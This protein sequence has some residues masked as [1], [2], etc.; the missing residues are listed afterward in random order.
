MEFGIFPAPVSCHSQ[1]D[2]LPALLSYRRGIMRALG[3]C[4]ELASYGYDASA[5]VVLLTGR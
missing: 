4:P 1:K 3:D 2:W 5:Q